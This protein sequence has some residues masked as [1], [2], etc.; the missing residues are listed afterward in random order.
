MHTRHTSSL[1]RALA[2]VFAISRSQVADAQT[3]TTAPKPES[4]DAAAWAIDFLGPDTTTPDGRTLNAGARYW[5]EVVGVPFTRDVVVDIPNVELDLNLD[6]TPDTSFAG[7]WELHGGI[8][9]NPALVGLDATPNDPAGTVGKYSISTGF[10]GVRQELDPKTREGTGRYAFNCWVCHGSVDERG[11]VQFGRPN[12]DINLGLIMAA[13]NVF[14]SGWAIRERPDAQPMSPQ[15]L[16]QR[17]GLDATFPLDGDGDG[18]V[19]IAEWRKA[20]RMPPAEVDAALMLLAGPGRL[21]QSIDRRMDGN[22][23]LAN[24]QQRDRQLYGADLY[25]RRARMSKPTVF[26]PVSIP[27]AFS[28]L[29]VRHYSYSAKDSS[30]R[31]SGAIDAG[32]RLHLP[33]EQLLALLHIPADWDD[34]ERMQRALTLDFRNNGTFGL[35]VDDTR[36]IGW[37]TDVIEHPAPDLWTHVAPL[38][39]AFALR[40]LLTSPPPRVDDTSELVRRGREIFTRRVTGTIINQRVVW[41]RE[42]TLP[43]RFEGIAALTPIDRSKPLEAKVEVSCASCHN[44][45][46]LVRKLPIHTPLEEMQ[47]CDICHFDHPVLD[48]SGKHRAAPES[49]ESLRSQMTKQKIENI[50]ECVDCHAEHPDFG[51]QVFSNSWVLPFDANDNRTTNGDEV[52]DSA[53]GGIGTDAYLNLETL[54]TVQ[55]RRLEDRP[56]RM[57]LTTIDPHRIPD[58]AAFSSKGNGWV[59]VTPLRMLRYT[60]PYLHNGSAPTLAALLEAPDKR[61][62]MFAVGNESQHFMYDTSL[63]GNR[64]TGHLFGLA[65]NDDDKRALLA[66]LE[67]LR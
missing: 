43:K 35:E 10:L 32:E 67:Q 62:T 4:A 23:P 52:A 31:H 8:L 54:F 26:N 60:A 34:P 59:R 55:R 56:T 6:G 13:S 12:T 45:S 20:M 22:I 11:Q 7:H 28:G 1:F 17:E 39:G 15:D 9:G 21:D 29:G 51:P 48:E 16:M 27:S 53:A 66:F 37:A 41:G 40:G 44:Y 3:P 47:R 64:N 14:N 38:F 24:M 25:L 65:L 49:F 46:P 42:V 18:Q 50:E 36:G 58:V 33:H 63:P 2:L 61:P 19:T 5:S 30:T 57:Y